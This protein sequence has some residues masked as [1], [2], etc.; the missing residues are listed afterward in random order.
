MLVLDSTLD[1]VLVSL[2][3]LAFPITVPVAD[4]APVVLPRLGSTVD[5]WSKGE[6]GVGSRES[7]VS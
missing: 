4:D 3:I 5:W 7:L 6:N 2:P 1:L